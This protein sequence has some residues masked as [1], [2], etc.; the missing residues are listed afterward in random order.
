MKPLI[1]LLFIFTISL[2]VLKYIRGTYNVA[3]SARIAMSGMLLF[4]ALGHFMF[5]EGMTL[6][7]PKCIPFKSEVIYIAAILEIV[8]ACSLHNALLRVFAAWSLLLFF[9]LLLPANIKASLEHINYQTAQL[10]GKG[11]L[12]LVFRIPLQI[13]FMAWVFFSAIKL[14]SITLK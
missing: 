14:E 10:D 3:F 1:V 11:L 2:F 5:T 6:M 9:I 8:A 7:L 12:Y 13:F 4:T